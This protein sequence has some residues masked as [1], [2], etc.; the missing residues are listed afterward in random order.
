MVGLSETY[1]RKMEKITVRA[2]R[3]PVSSF[4]SASA[5]LV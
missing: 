1:D 2:V 3:N 5:A 4:L